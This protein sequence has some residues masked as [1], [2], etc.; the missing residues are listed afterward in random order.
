MEGI[1]ERFGASFDDVRRDPRPVLVGLAFDAIALALLGVVVLAAA[2]R[3]PLARFVPFAVPGA[4]AT[5]TDVLHVP[6]SAVSVAG[7][8]EGTAAAA[9]LA[10]ALAPIAAWLEGGAVGV[11][12]AA[13]VDRDE[14]PLAPAFRAAARRSFRALLAYR[15]LLHG[16]LVA[17]FVL[18]R[19]FPAYRSE[20]VGAIVLEFLLVFTP[21]IVVLEGETAWGGMKRSAAAVADHLTTCLI[22]L[23]FGLL[24]T[25][26]ASA[27]V[28]ELSESLGG[29]IVIAAVVVYAPVG[30]ALA[31]FTMKVWL[32][33]QPPEQAPA[34]TVPATA[35][36]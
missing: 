2:G 36:A 23:L 34:S 10:I 35:P 9:A 4:L 18:G 15:L 12:K 17:G 6:S 25:G 5:F 24:V 11:L 29:W 30:T 19:M 7:L 14:G 26:G 33:F 21:Y 16:A 13:Y 3:L 8:V 22:M 28:R 1:G 31:I 27:I 20:T 32:G